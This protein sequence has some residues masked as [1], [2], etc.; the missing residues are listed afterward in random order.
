MRSDMR[1]EA[2]VFQLTPTRTRCDLVIVANGKT[3]K[4]ASG[5]LNP[6][7]SHLK[8][9]RIKS[10]K[11]AI[12]SNLYQIQLQK[13]HG[14]QRT[15]WRG[16]NHISALWFVRFVSTLR[17]KN[18]IMQN[19]SEAVKVSQA[20]AFSCPNAGSKR[21]L[22]PDADKAIVLY[23]VRVNFLCWKKALFVFMNL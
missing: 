12:L 14:S 15:L 8:T 23:K 4:I 1:L 3:E 5:L 13:R 10:E 18:I 2:T 19:Q 7:L 20:L 16:L 6:F 21:L 22:D 11:A 17:W 9:A